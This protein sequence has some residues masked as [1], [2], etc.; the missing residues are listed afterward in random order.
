MRWWPYYLVKWSMIKAV[1]NMG[2]GRVYRHIRRAA[3]RLCS[4]READ[5]V[6]THVKKALLLP[7]EAEQQISRELA[8]ID[9]FLMH[10]AVEPLQTAEMASTKDG[11]PPS[12]ED[13]ECEKTLRKGLSRFRKWNARAGKL[14]GHTMAPDGRSFLQRSMQLRLQIQTVRCVATGRLD[15]PLSLQQSASVYVPD[16]KMTVFS[17]KHLLAA[18]TGIPASQQQLLHEQRVLQD[19]STLERAGVLPWDE[20][21]L[22]RV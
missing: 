8:S 14:A 11:L 22:T 16:S 1:Q 6:C 15:G 2:A 20:L 19:W 9:R 5:R 21:V 18:E 4:P 7:I 17:L 3:H 12:A 13:S 10:W